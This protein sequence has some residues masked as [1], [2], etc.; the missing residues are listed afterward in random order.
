MPASE[1]LIHIN[2]NKVAGHIAIVADGAF[3]THPHPLKV[4]RN[5]DKIICCDNAVLKLERHCGL[6]CDLIAGDMD[7]MSPENQI[8]YKEIIHKE[9]E[10]EHN[11]MT[12]AFRLAMTLKPEKISILGATGLREDHTL[13][14][15]SLVAEYAKVFRN[16]EMITDYGIFFPLLDSSAIKCRKGEQISIFAFDQTLRIKSAGLKY[17]TG[18]VVFDLW[19]K[20]TLNEALEEDVHLEFSHPARVIVFRNYQIKSPRP[21][22][23]AA[24]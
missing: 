10:Q 4:L 18:N 14:N 20:A 23:G 21:G 17:P 22:T 6:R 19:W 12:K 15:I 2:S 9:S 3:P 16:I 5:A 24:R 7:S 13:G 1:I 11:D 8:K